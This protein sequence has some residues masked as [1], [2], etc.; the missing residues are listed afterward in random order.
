MKSKSKS[1]SE[2][3]RIYITYLK[4]KHQLFKLKKLKEEIDHNRS[5][6]SM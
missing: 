4:Q 5:I 6:S 1:K 3:A 2:I